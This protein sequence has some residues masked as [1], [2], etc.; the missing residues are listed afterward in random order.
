MRSGNMWKVQASCCRLL[1]LSARS[2]K[3]LQGCRRKKMQSFGI[4][5]EIALCAILNLST[6]SLHHDIHLN[7]WHISKVLSRYLHSPESH[8]KVGSTCPVSTQSQTHI[9][10]MAS[11]DFKN[12]QNF[13]FYMKPFATFPLGNTWH[14]V[15]ACHSM[16]SPR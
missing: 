11:H 15:K 2:C 12:G 3:V 13:L 7:Q 1:C 16:E 14:R 4:C 6:Y 5:D 10:S 9:A 8:Q